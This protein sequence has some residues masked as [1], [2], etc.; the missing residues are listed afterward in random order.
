M[1]QLPFRWGRNSIYLQSLY[2]SVRT[3][4]GLLIVVNGKNL[5]L[6]VFLLLL[7]VLFLSL[8]AVDTTRTFALL[9]FH[10]AIHRKTGSGPVVVRPHPQSLVGQ[11]RQPQLQPSLG[12]IFSLTKSQSTTKYRLDP[13]RQKRSCTSLCGGKN[14]NNKNQESS[15]R[16][17]AIDAMS[18]DSDINETTNNNKNNKTKKRGVIFDIDGT[19]ADS[20]KLGFDATN[21]VLQN[22]GIG[23]ISVE[24]YHQGTRYTTPERLAR[25]AGYQPDQ[26]GYA[27]KGQQLAQEFDNLYTGLVS[28][29]TAQFYPGL[30]DLLLRISSDATVGALTNAAVQYAHAVL[31]VNSCP[32]SKEEEE[33]KQP[34]SQGDNNNNENH[35]EHDERRRLQLY[36]RFQS[37]RGADNVPRAKP[38][39]DGLW[40]V[41]QDLDLL[42]H[43]C[44]YIGDSPSDGVAA[45]A[46]G[47]S[48]VGVTWGSHSRASLAC[49]SVDMVAGQGNNHNNNNDNEPSGKDDVD[50]MDNKDN[51]RVLICDTVDDLQMALAAHSLVS[52]LDFM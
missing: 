4:T 9:S 46:A 45:L 41:C 18:A 51:P 20:W 52:S 37:I 36:R 27:T 33:T 16:T 44:V 6:M 39:P 19:L 38:A 26:E 14:N 13:P 3:T 8:T 5:S 10:Q 11:R 17:S 7:V 29:E 28:I 43:E 30:Q 21:V 23:P 22:N 31:Q 1:R 48:F 47:M 12:L 40:T 35:K 25:H 15:L 2:L 50:R 24:T 34:S 49:V 32:L 42:P